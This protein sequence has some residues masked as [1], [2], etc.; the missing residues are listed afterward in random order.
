MA[1]GDRWSDD[2]NVKV[3]EMRNAETVLG[4]ITKHRPLASRLR[5]KD[6]RAVLGGAEGKGRSRLPVTAAALRAHELRHKPIP[7]QPPTLRPV[8]FGGGRMEKDAAGYPS[9]LTH[10]GS[11]TP[12]SDGTSPAAYPT[13]IATTVKPFAWNPAGNQS[14]PEELGQQPEASLEEIREEIRCQFIILARK[15]ELT[16]DFPRKDELTP[17]FLPVVEAWPDLPEALK[18]GIVAMVKSIAESWR[19]GKPSAGNSGGGHLNAI[20]VLERRSQEGQVRGYG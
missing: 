18:T 3:R 2:P 4:V 6:S 13:R 12:A 16:P 15:D 14:R 10:T 20:G 19:E 11:R 8:R 7:R 1:K 17:D 5:S 9:R